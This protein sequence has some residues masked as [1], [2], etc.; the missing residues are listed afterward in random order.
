VLQG[1]G[2]DVGLIT[3]PD[4]PYLFRNFNHNFGKGS[5]D[6]K[7]KTK[8]LGFGTRNVRKMLVGSYAYI[9]F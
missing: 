5:K 9:H 3:P 4:K 2:L 6:Y 7:K 8:K 1:G